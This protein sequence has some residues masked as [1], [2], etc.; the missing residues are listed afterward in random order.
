MGVTSGA[1]AG[2]DFSNPGDG[3]VAVRKLGLLQRRTLDAGLLGNSSTGKCDDG[4]SEQNFPDQDFSPCG[5]RLAAQ[6]SPEKR[7]RRISSA[8]RHTSFQRLIPSKTAAM[9]R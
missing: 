8:R 2:G 5:E 7:A 4:Q 1:T 6:L 3:I 9:P